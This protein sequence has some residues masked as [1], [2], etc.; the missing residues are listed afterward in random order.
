[1]NRLTEAERVLGLDVSASM[2]GRWYAEE[3][4]EA[5]VAARLASVEA[6]AV[7]LSGVGSHR[8][9]CRLPDEPCSCGLCDFRAEAAAL[10]AAVL[11]SDAH[12]EQRG[13]GE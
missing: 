13:T 2:P 3:V 11:G 8:Y 12:T 10:I 6:L 5:I 4:V 1:M 7:A 9:W